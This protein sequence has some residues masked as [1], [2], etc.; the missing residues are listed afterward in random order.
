VSSA[1]LIKHRVNS[2]DKTLPV[3]VGQAG[4]ALDA[5][6]LSNVGVQLSL[7]DG[8][9]LVISGLCQ[10]ALLEALLFVKAVALQQ[11]LSR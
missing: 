2:S 5:G 6:T 4:N 10:L 11:A 9:L 1:K 3:L 8:A 7:G